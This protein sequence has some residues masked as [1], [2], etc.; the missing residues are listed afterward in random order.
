MND[1]NL[2]YFQLKISPVLPIR[3][4]NGKRYV[5]M[6]SYIFQ[7]VINGSTC[8]ELTMKNE[9]LKVTTVFTTPSAGHKNLRAADS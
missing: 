7:N 6:R 9:F 2:P 4:K 1:Q 8:V 3:V 5:K